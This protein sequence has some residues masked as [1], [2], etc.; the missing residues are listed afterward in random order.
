MGLPFL[1]SF[2]TKSALKVVAWPLLTAV[3]L[4]AAII[5]L[6][7]QQQQPDKQGAVAAAPTW[8]LQDMLIPSV[9]VTHT[10]IGC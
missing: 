10:S 9:G 8:V 2:P 7:V 6:Q 1:M 5:S 4:I 3:A